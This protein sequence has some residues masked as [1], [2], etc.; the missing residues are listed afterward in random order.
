VKETLRDVKRYD[1]IFENKLSFIEDAIASRRIIDSSTGEIVELTDEMLDVRINEF[2][3]WFES[4]WKNIKA[5]RDMGVDWPFLTKRGDPRG[6]ARGIIRNLRRQISGYTS[7]VPGGTRR[8]FLPIN[9][10]FYIDRS[11]FKP[12]LTGFKEDFIAHLPDS[13][14]LRL[15][16]KFAGFDDSAPIVNGILNSD[17]GYRLVYEDPQ[18]GVLRFTRFRDPDEVVPET[19]RFNASVGSYGQMDSGIDDAAGATRVRSSEDPYEEVVF[20]GVSTP[21]QERME[22][23]LNYLGFAAQ[24]VVVP[25]TLSRILLTRT[26]RNC[27]AFSKS[28]MH[29][30]LLLRHPF[31]NFLLRFLTK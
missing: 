5:L 4:T 16:P 27:D 30:L 3:D 12:S 25:D 14:E 28:P 15:G 8:L 1:E 6:G 22:L 9:Q 24:P 19:G 2:V 31:R 11:G 17:Y 26:S 23:G 21:W 18:D 10:V 29:L 7:P 20:T 13:F